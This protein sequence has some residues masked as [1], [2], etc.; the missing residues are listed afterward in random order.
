MGAPAPRV[1]NGH[2][3]LYNFIF[4]IG[5]DFSPYIVEASALAWGVTGFI[6]QEAT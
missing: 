3:L 1:V 2:P 5:P 6:P 4:F